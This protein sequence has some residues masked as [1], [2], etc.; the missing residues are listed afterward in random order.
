MTVGI[1]IFHSHLCCFDTAPSKA[2]D[3]PTMALLLKRGKTGSA[4][5]LANNF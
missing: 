4:G 3:M 2:K 5:V 1:I